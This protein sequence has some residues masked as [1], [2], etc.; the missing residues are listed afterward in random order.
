MI[1]PVLWQYCVS[2]CLAGTLFDFMGTVCISRSGLG[3]GV[4]LLLFYST[5][6]NPLLVISTPLT[7]APTTPPPAI[8]LISTWKGLRA[9][10]HGLR[11]IGASSPQAFYKPERM[12]KSSQQGRGIERESSYRGLPSRQPGVKD[13]DK[14]QGGSNRGGRKGK[15]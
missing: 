12:E 9:H 7:P 14:T 1:C 8:G 11:L 2:P 5:C 6:H 4:D 13:T 15:R 10:Y 3:L